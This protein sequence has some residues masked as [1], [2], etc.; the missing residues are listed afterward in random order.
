M[1]RAKVVT[2]IIIYLFK[3]LLFKQ[4]ISISFIPFSLMKWRK[5][6]SQFK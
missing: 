2:K 6:F 3:F 1:N 4:I 5:M